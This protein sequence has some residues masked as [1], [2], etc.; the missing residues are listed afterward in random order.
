MSA[1]EESVAAQVPE[2]AAGVMAY[3]EARTDD[4]LLVGAVIGRLL[5][6]YYAKLAI[7]HD[8]PAGVAIKAVMVAGGAA[9]ELAGRL[10]RS[11]QM[12]DGE[13]LS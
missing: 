5:A 9:A 2:L 7:D 1:E 8:E 3:I 12:G 13:N 11:R 6:G 4:R 10:V